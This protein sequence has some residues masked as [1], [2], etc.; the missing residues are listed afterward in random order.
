MLPL[1]GGVITGRSSGGRSRGGGGSGGGVGGVHHGHALVVPRVAAGLGGLVAGLQGRADAA[2]ELPNLT[3]F[4]TGRS[5]R[6][7]QR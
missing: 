2:V 1:L 3:D 4:G 7:R 6:E 5:E